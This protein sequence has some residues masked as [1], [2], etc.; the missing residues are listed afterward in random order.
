MQSGFVRVGNG[1]SSSQ[2]NYLFRNEGDGTLAQLNEFGLLRTVGMAWGD[3]DNDGDLDLALGNGLLG[4]DQQNML[5]VNNGDG[6]FTGEEQFGM[7]QSA[8]VVWGDCDGDGDLDLA[9]GNGGFGTEEQNY[10]YRNNGDGTF[11]EEA[12]FG[13]E[14]TAS[15]A[16]GDYDND[17]DLDLA[18]GNWQNGPSVLYTNDGTGH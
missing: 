18:V 6:T 11:T 7:G 14:D 8:A 1:G 5:Y 3:Y 10:L 16:W 9:V 2:Q 4:G 17:G 12:N 15:L 13:Q